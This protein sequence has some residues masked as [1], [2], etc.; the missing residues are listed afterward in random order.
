MTRSMAAHHGP[1]GIRVN[2][3]APGMVYTSFVIARGM[4]DE[5]RDVRREHS[6]LKTEGTGWDIGSG[7]LYLAS[8]LARWV[9]G[10][11]LPIDAGI[12]AA[13]AL[14]TPP[15]SLAAPGVLPS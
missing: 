12:T 9:T 13:T 14:P 7:V 8:D 6:L 10:I 4:S 2:C 5:M 3:I 11:T 15:R 1:D